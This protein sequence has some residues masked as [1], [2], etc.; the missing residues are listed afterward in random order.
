MPNNDGLWN[1]LLIWT[2]HPIAGYQD[3]VPFGA[4]SGVDP[5]ATVVLG[6][7]TLNASTYHAEWTVA[8][9]LGMLTITGATGPG[10]VVRFTAGSGATGTFDL[11]THAWHRDP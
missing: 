8:G 4:T 11:T 6:A 2:G 5:R 10:G 1:P 3:G 7:F 9:S